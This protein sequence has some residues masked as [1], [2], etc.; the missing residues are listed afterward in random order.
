[1]STSGARSWRDLREHLGR[2]HDRREL[3]RFL[4]AATGYEP[5]PHQLRAHLAHAE[6]ADEASHK[7][8]LG[9]VGAGKTKWGAAETVAMAIANPGSNLCV[10]APTFDQ[11][12]HVVVP[13]LRH[14]FDEMAARGYPLAKRWKHSTACFELVGGGRLFARSFDRVD[15]IRG[16][17]FS[18]IHLDETSMARRPTYVFDTLQGRLRD[19]HANKLQIHVTTTPRGLHGV[20]GKFIAH[21]DAAGGLPPAEA[22]AARRGWWVGRAPT[23]ANTHLPPGY[24]ESLKAGYSTRQWQQEVEAKILRP[25]SSVFPEFSRERHMRPWRY[26]P[27]IGA[28]DLAIDWGHSHPAVLFIQRIPGTGELVIFDEFVEDNVPRDH[29]RQYIRRACDKLGRPPSNIAADRAVKSENSWAIHTFTSTRLHVMR[30]RQQQDIRNGLEC[31]RAMLDPVDRAPL[32]YVADHLAQ[33]PPRR[34]IVPSLEKYRYRQR[35]DGSLSPEP[36]KCNVFDHQID[37]LRYHV[38]G[39]GMDERK[40]YVIGRTHGANNPTD[41]FERR[42]RRARY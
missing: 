37:A 10:L 36:Y 30:S 1:M 26:D 7:L 28:Y 18:A 42:G 23:M 27:T 13:E 40:A 5:L 15:S 38:V 16:F 20:V 19:S 39:C 29:L 32:L 8:F 17:Q 21:R 25:E 4:C 11:I 34:G 12:L 35:S 9:G 6:R 41:Y 3:L 31:V 2:Q 24:V 22:S 14:L 33:D